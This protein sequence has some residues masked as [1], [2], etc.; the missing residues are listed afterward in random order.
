MLEGVYVLSTYGPLLGPGGVAQGC[1]PYP[2]QL[3]LCVCKEIGK[4]MSGC[5]C[6]QSVVL[7]LLFRYHHEHY[8]YVWACRTPAHM[9]GKIG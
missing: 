5:G 2:F 8:Y 9:N 3:L 1:G 4:K 7:V 6:G